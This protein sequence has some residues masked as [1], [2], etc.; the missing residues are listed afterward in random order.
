[1]KLLT[2]PYYKSKPKCS[3]FILC[4]SFLL[5]I[6]GCFSIPGFCQ[7]RLFLPL[8]KITLENGLSSPNVRKIIQDK[9][10]FVWLGTQ[11]GLNRYDGTGFQYFNADDPQPNRALSASDVYDLFSDATSGAIWV[12]TAYGGLDKVDPVTCTVTGRYRAVNPQNQQSLWLK[13]MDSRNS[14]IVAG[15]DE[16]MALRYNMTDA[17]YDRSIDLA[18]MFGVKG[19]VDEVFID[20]QNRIWWFISGAGILLTNID[21][22]RKLHFIPFPGEHSFTDLI[23]YDQQL[24]VTTTRGLKLFSIN[25][26][27]ET[28]LAGFMPGLPSFLK[29]GELHSIYAGN[30]SVLIAGNDR[31]YRL[32]PSTKR[33]EEICFSKNYEDKKWLSLTNSVYQSG[34]SIWIGSQYGLGY[35]RN[36]STPFTAYYSSMADGKTQIQHSITICPA[37][38]S[39]TI[40]CADDGLYF[41]NQN[42]G[43]ISKYPVRGFYYAALQGPGN[44]VIASA[45]KKALQVLNSRGESVSLAKTFPELLPIRKDLLIG[46]AR[47]GDSLYLLASQLQKGI[48]IWNTKK[49]TLRSLNT[50]STPALKSNVINRLYVDSRNLLWVICDNT[51][52]IYNPATNTIRHLALINTATKMPLSIIMDVCEH[53]KQFWLAAYGTGII[54]LSDDLTVQKIFSLKEGINSLGLYKIFSLNDSIV[55]SSSNNGLTVLNTKTKTAINYFEQDGLQ[56]SSFEE[57]SGAINGPAILAGGIRGFTKIEPEK[58]SL[59]RIAPLLFFSEMIVQSKKTISDTLNIF[60]SKLVVPPATNRVTVN[61]TALNFINP[62]KVSYQYKLEGSN[63]DWIALGHKNFVSFI[64]IRPGQYSLF[65][66][67]SNED[68]I[69]SAPIKLSLIFLPKWYQTWWFKLIL[70]L[71][72]AATVYG[73]YRLRL[74]QLKKE[75]KIRTRLAGDLHDD[76]GGTLN[77]IK[78]YTDLAMMEGEKSPYLVK[79]RESTREAISGIKDMI[80]VLDDRKDT[81]EDLLARISQFGFPL[82]QASRISYKQS[83]NEEARSHKLG[84]EEKRNL[85]MILKEAINNA[86]K[87][88]GASEVTV[89]IQVTKKRPGIRI[90]DNGR[91]FDPAA[92]SEG[93]GLKNMQ[94]RSREIGYSLEI[95]ASPGKGTVIHLQKLN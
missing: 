13:C 60:F 90:A 46:S 43:V 3:F 51:V 82:C 12:L 77:S 68:G 67:A 59:N 56:S 75:Q 19:P 44:F 93:N 2:N 29:E 6:T 55:M 62:E 8:T 94:L 5:L 73:L 33:T 25:N 53:N 27:A 39:M 21:I 31:L 49:R 63:G 84:R 42:S 35:I 24:L 30:G 58:F 81:I 10:G 95:N 32:H 15:S 89:A 79:V 52:S 38:D 34:R 80:W 9:Y 64:D 20:S 14:Y 36:D 91:G 17:K 76:L 54:Q 70:T 48:Y 86:C 85:Y 74:N 57:A 18:K 28:G 50:Q 61:F 92:T 71:L 37:N 41:V 47:Y 16:G 7:S 87:Y 69:W 11:D 45:E 22:S 65:V 26:T 40:I 23:P 83:F 78:I 1:M 66:R 72:F 88:A 4:K